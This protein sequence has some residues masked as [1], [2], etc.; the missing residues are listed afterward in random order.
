MLCFPHQSVSVC[1][2]CDE[3]FKVVKGFLLDSLQVLYSEQESFKK[4]ATHLFY[5]IHIFDVI[6][7]ENSKDKFI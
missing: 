2:P 7:N 5:Y 1:C 4:L 3:S 6:C